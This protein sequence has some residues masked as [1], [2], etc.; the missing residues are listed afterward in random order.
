MRQALKKLDGIDRRRFVEY[1]A[2]SILGVSVLP[3]LDRAARAA[4]TGGAGGRAKRLVYLF[5]SGGMT[6]L[7]TF[8]LKPGH[9]ETQDILLNL[10]AEHADWTGARKTLNAKLKHGA[11]PRDV[12]KRRDAVLA[13]SEARDVLAEGKTIEARESAIEAFLAGYCGEDT[14]ADPLL[15]LFVLEKAAYEVAYEAANRPDWMAVPVSGL[16]ATAERLM[17]GDTT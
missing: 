7:D 9:E 16:V 10:Q 8:D 11:L 1:A 4:Q 12:H 15:D 3:A 6:H 14:A 2:K 17:S 13:L 5:M